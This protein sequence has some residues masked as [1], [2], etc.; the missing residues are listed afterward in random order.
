[1]P[2][3]KLLAKVRNLCLQKTVHTREFAE[4]MKNEGTHNAIEQG[5][6]IITEFI[7]TL[8][9]RDDLLDKIKQ[10]HKHNWKKDDM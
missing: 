4:E 1:M 9:E 5:A 7:K 10:E 8:S 2:E 6:Q 3:E